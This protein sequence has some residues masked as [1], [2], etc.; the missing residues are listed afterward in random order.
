MHP[1]RWTKRHSSCFYF[2]WIDW[3]SLYSTVDATNSRE[4]TSV[5]WFSTFPLTADSSYWEER[6]AVEASYEWLAN[7]GAL[8]PA[9]ERLLPPSHS[10]PKL[11]LVGC[12]NSNFSADLFDAGW[13]D[14]TSTDFSE[15]IC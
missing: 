13:T 11:L 9:L 2:Q 3:D 8:R 12:G 14:I 15:V 4:Y 1:T 7:F 6:F 10:H 5:D